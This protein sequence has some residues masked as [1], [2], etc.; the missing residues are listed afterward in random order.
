MTNNSERIRL[1]VDSVEGEHC[2]FKEA[3]TSFEFD[4]LLQ[5]CS[6]L[7]N[8][9]G[10]R[11]V[12]GVTDRRP[13]RVVG[14]NAFPQFDK[15]RTGLMEKLHLRVEVEEVISPEGRVLIFTVPTR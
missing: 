14:T 9:G 6:A 1:L 3:K 10:G 7:A 13:R 12:L 5:Y 8:E 11:I 15:I 2:E 4:K